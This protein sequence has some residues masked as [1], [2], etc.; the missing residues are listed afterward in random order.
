MVRGSIYDPKGK[1]DQ[2]FENR[3]GTHGELEWTR[4]V[5]SD[6]QVFEETV[7]KRG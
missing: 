2:E 7:K 5:H 1:L 6:G 4:A 3:Y